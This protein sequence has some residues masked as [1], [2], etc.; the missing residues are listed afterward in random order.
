MYKVL[1]TDIDLKFK[2][3]TR[4]YSYT[5]PNFSTTEGHDCMKSKGKYFRAFLKKN[6]QKTGNVPGYE[7]VSYLLQ[8]IRHWFL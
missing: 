5:C 4:L 3:S 8:S 2:I 1:F 6:T 7:V